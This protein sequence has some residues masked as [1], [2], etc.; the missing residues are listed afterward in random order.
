[1][2]LLTV[3]WQEPNKEQIAEEL[4]NGIVL[5]KDKT[6]NPIGMELLSYK[7]GD[8]RFDSVSVEVGKQAFPIQSIAA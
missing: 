2:E 7:P 8:E 4:G 6:G 5:I 1:M 3:F